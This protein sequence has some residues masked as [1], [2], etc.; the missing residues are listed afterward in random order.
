[1]SADPKAMFSTAEVFR[2]GSGILS[3]HMPDLMFPMV[4]CASFSLE[5]YL[6]SLVL[7]ESGTA[8]RGHNLETLFSKIS[9]A[10]QGAIRKNY[11][12]K[13]SVQDAMLAASNVPPLPKA[14]FDFVLH[15]SAEAFENFRYA[16]EGIVKDQTGWLAGPIGECVRERII[17]LH[18]DW[19]RP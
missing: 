7:L 16:Y 1:M 18:P 9:P 4:M 14:D 17:E 2:F 10:S 8:E 11:E 5:L 19:A 15:A 12:K 6:K 3:R 13:R